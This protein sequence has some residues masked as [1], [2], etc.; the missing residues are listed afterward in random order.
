MARRSLLE[1]HHLFAD[2][3]CVAD[4]TA[5]GM[6]GLFLIYLELKIFVVSGVEDKNHVLER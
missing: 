4:Y 6:C 1:T 5:V 2:C 3:S